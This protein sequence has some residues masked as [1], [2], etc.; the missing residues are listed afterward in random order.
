MYIVQYVAG[1]NLA[2]TNILSC[3]VSSLPRY[4]C[5]FVCTDQKYL[6]LYEQFRNSGLRR[7]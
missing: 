3:L 4:R 6:V 5:T 1:E 7:L 2:N